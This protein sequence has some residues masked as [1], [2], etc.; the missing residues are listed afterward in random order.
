MYRRFICA[1]TLSLVVGVLPPATAF[2]QTAEEVRGKALAVLR[3]NSTLEQKWAACRDLARVGDKDCVPVLARMLADEKL[4]HMARYALE[5]IPDKSVDESLRAVADKLNGKLLSG[6]INSIGARRDAAAVEGLAKHLGDSD[7]DVVRVAAIALG[8][9]G[10][11]TAGNAL[12]ASFK[13]AKGEA[14]AWISEG[15][16]NCGANLAAQGKQD[17][18][19]AVYDGM[20]TRSLPARFRVAAF[21]GAILCDPAGRLKR[22]RTMLQDQEYCVFAMALRVA[23]EMKDKHVTGVLVSEVGKLPVD[24]VVPV[25][26]ILGQCGDKAALPLLLELAKKGKVDVRLE[27]I[28]SAA[29]IGDASAVL[30]LVDLMKDTDATIGRAATTALVGL[31]G[32]QVDAAIVQLLES[33]DRILR[34][35]VLEI[36]RERRIAGALPMLLKAMADTDITVRTAAAR[37]YGEIAGADGLPALIGVLVK[38]TDSGEIELYERLLGSACRAAGDKD[39]CARRLAA[40]MCDAKPVVKPALLRMLRVAGGPEALRAIR[41]AVDDANK[42]VHAVALRVLCEWTSA[43]AAPILLELAKSAAM[44][45]D[46]LA[47][48]RGCLGIALQNSVAAREK[49]AICHQVAPIIHREEEKRMLLGALGSA[50]SAE[51]LDLIVPYLDDIAVKREAV[52]T[53]LAIAEKRKPKE[54]AGAMMVALQKV[55]K[56]AADDPGVEKRA[57][58]LLKQI[59]NEK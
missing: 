28:Q 30:A 52:A 2:G 16:L 14:I 1:I 47:A 31:P 18:A 3:S 7:A 24:R 10:T 33:P 12:L 38:S 19:K 4:S 13:D 11:E 5:P 42:E 39:A 27:A 55:V 53:V 15:L 56:I 35:H 23:A 41:G 32:L 45:A 50:A 37:S 36:A 49:L 44:P 17:A 51:S 20:M 6:V 25:V 21:R 40:A 48:L 57:E 26:K 34:L 9:I 46:R 29:E 43:D 59:D 54:Y 8:R 58:E 22:F